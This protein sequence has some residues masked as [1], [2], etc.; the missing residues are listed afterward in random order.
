M[1]RARAAAVAREVVARS[2]RGSIASIFAGGSLARSEVWATTIEGSVEIYSDVD[3]YVVV[4]DASHAGAVAAACRAAAAAAPVAI[5]GVRFLRAPD[6][7]VYSRDDLSAQ[8]LR[9][10]T[11]DLASRHVHLHGDP[12]IAAQLPR[13][14]AQSIPA[15]EALYLLENRAMEL[16]AWETS[17]GERLALVRALKAR[18]DVH[19]AHAIV[20]G[21]FAPTLALRRESLEKSPA[22]T[23]EPGLREELRAAYRA[24]A[25]VGA[26]LAGKSAENETRSALALLARAWCELAPIVLAG[27][28][29]GVDAVLLRRCQSGA[30]IAN[31]REAI[32]LR[33]FTGTALWLAAA[34]APALARLSP[35][36]A[37]RVDALV[38]EL[39]RGANDRGRGFAAHARYVDRLTRVFGFVTGDLEARV[40][41]MHRAIS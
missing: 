31:A 12:S 19:V 23:L 27:G 34:R 20:A 18:L 10:G 5:A 14:D 22:A 1:Q 38:R 8:P 39:S 30:W 2:P 21:S 32:R 7:G 16:A 29:D 33:R 40:R 24:A 28:S 37:L 4:S 35:R 11:I 17:G 36:A 15:Q 25:D 26:W 6:V 9:P 41:A 3:I 13:A